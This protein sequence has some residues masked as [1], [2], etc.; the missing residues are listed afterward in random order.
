VNAYY[1]DGGVVSVDEHTNGLD[2]PSTS[3]FKNYKLP[4]LCTQSSQE[5]QPGN[6]VATSTNQI[7][8]RTD[9]NT[10]V[11]FR[12]QKSFRF[13]GIRYADKPNRFEYSKV[14]SGTGQ[15]FQA[16]QY[17][18]ACAQG[19]GGSEDCL[20]LNI[21]TPYIPK[22]GSKSNL[23]PVHF[24]IHGG[25]FTGGSGSDAGSDGGNLASREDVVVVTINYRL[26]TLGFLAIPGTDIKG[27]F[28]IGD[29][30]QALK[31]FAPSNCL[32]ELKLTLYPVDCG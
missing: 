14:F 16:T 29:Q 24:W 2:F 28:G 25:G 18:S 3:E 5:S 22:A 20:F 31:V 19:G 27:N 13:L 8:V 9:S 15:T 26:S 10:Y 23:R 11:G 21:Q 32:H 12:N 6:A 1:I 17:G 7:S 4:V 30:V